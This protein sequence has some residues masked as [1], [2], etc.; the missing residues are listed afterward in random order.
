M[1]PLS[2]LPAGLT[3]LALALRLVLGAALPLGLAGQAQAQAATQS[4]E[5]D[6]P[7]GPLAAALNRYAQQAGVAIVVN[8]DALR[9]LD[10]AG[11]KGRHGVEEGFGILLRGSGYALGKTASGYVLKPAPEGAAGQ[12]ATLEEI[13]VRGAAVQETATARVEGYVARRGATGTKTDTP[14][15]ETPQSISVVTSDFIEATGATRLRDALAYTPG[16][17][18]SPW[19]SDSRFDW[20][21]IRGFDAQT[22]GYYLDGL[23][24]RNNNGWAV[25]Q[26]ENYGAERIEVLRGPSSVLYGQTGPGGMINVVSKRP[27]EEPL[28]ELQAQVGDHSRRQLAGDFS[29]PVDEN[30]KLLYRFTGLAREARL[31]GSDLRNDRLYLAPS[32]T[33]R[34]SSDTSLTLLS[35]YLRVR[36][37]SSYNGFPEV[38]TLLPNPNGRFSPKTYTGEPDFDHFNQSQWMVG[39]LLDHRVN[40]IWT[41][42]QNARYG[43]IKTDYLQVYN[44]SDFAVVNPAVPDDPANFRVLQRYPF[45][46]KES[47]RLFTID[48]QAQAKVSLGEWQHTLLFGV[49]Y[50]RS[51]N[52]QRT[53]NSG[54]VSNIDGYDPVHTNDVRPGTPWFDARTSLSQTGFY[55]QDQIKWGNWVATLGGRHDS[56]TTRVQSHLDGSDTRV[57]DRKFTSRAGLVYLHPSGWAPYVSYSES[58]SPTAT[59]DPETNTPLKPETGRQYEAGL[60]YQPADGKSRYGIAVFDLRRRNYITYTPTFQPKQT[61]EISVRGLELEAAFQPLRNMNVVLAYTYTPRAIVTASSTP[62]EIG[63][64]MQAV[65][66]NQFSVW[67]DYR[68]MGLK[69]GLG[70]RF[71]GSN[72]G[73]QESASAPVPSYTVMDAMLGYDFERWSLALNVRNLTNKAYISNCSAGICRYG[74]LRTAVATATYRW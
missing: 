72:L 29:G 57:T 45:S 66:R 49:D 69:M 26:T 53:D 51:R 38:G 39:Y 44:K 11:L 47:A 16:I 35:H 25:W 64:Q 7:A 28:H 9:G 73:Y 56:A 15:I 37:G 1:H 30:G 36:D 52:D 46:S 17:N 20:T 18:V 10:C 4:I 24:L 19:G 13:K 67:T 58:F 60:R 8:A 50:Q 21:I 61:G 62:S 32:F 65:S 70:A 34:P 63:K 22:P 31:P 59:I 6:V 48:N 71:M 14:L 43:A 55:L 23:P 54:T 5:Y 40:D 68:Y 27:V 74:D 41:L 33:L 2:K 42:R 3:P 12:A